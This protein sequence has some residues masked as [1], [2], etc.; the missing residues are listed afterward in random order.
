[1]NYLGRF[2]A[3]LSA[4]Q[5]KVESTRSTV[6]NPNIDRRTA[7]RAITDLD[8]RSEDSDTDQRTNC[9]HR[10][11]GTLTG[12]CIRRSSIWRRAKQNC[13]VV[14]SRGNEGKEREG[15]EGQKGEREEACQNLLSGCECA[16]CHSSRSR[17]PH[18][19]Q[20]LTVTE[21]RVTPRAELAAAVRSVNA[22]LVQLPSSKWPDLPGPKW[23]ELIAKVDDL[24][25]QGHTDKALD[26]A[27]RWEAEAVERIEQVIA[28]MGGCRRGG[29]PR[30][31]TGV[32][33]RAAPSDSAHTGQT[34]S[35]RRSA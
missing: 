21:L 15:K 8:G 25:A 11:C 23:V 18:S 12:V 31:N 19:G 29:V 20:S 17:S 35:R 4:N 33:E 14:Q 3:R 27:K 9:A 2:T 22:R 16:P 10:K 24:E 13:E 34:V 30:A 26:L 7:A 1:M 6:E 5:A 32:T 28:E